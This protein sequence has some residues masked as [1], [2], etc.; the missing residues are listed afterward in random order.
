MFKF[1]NINGKKLGDAILFCLYCVCFLGVEILFGIKEI[2]GDFDLSTISLVVARGIDATF[3]PVIIWGVCGALVLGAIGL[4]LVLFFVFDKFEKKEN[5]VFSLKVMAGYLFLLFGVVVWLFRGVLDREIFFQLY[6]GIVLGYLI[7]QKREFVRGAR[8]MMLFLFVLGFVVWGNYKNDFMR[9]VVNYD[10]YFVEK[11]DDLII[12]NKRNLIVIFAESFEE[13]FSEIEHK[14][15]KN[16]IKDEDAVKFSD[17]LEG[18]LQGTTIEALCAAIN[19]VHIGNEGKYFEYFLIKNKLNTSEIGDV[20]ELGVKNKLGVG[21]ILENNGY[22]NIFVK[23]GNIK[24]M[25]TDSFL[26]REGFD[27]KNIYDTKAFAGWKEFIRKQKGNWWGPSDK[28]VLAKFKEKILSVEKGKP[29]FAVMFTCDLHA[30]MGDLYK[31]PFFDSDEEIINA[32]I[33]NLNEF[34]EWFKKQEFYENTSLVIVADHR[35][36]G[37]GDRKKKEKLYNAFFNVPEELKKD[38]RV[39]REFNQI[40]MAPTLLE[41]AGVKLKERRYG[42]GVSLFS[43]E[44]TLAER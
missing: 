12:K 34:I 4:T 8:W 43:K 21:H 13:R 25:Q 22:K 31:N 41:L 32:T 28:E 14:G 17:F 24:F 42:L 38:L 36:M 20:R 35:K 5:R 3:N 39:E 10:D 6:L 23:G 1:V 37:D 29:F 15:V 9:L 2:W 18:K 26:L 19:G 16:R 11:T 44:K 27:R 30:K 33:D 7:I 40:D